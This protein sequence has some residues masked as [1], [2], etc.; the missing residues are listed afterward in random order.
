M[1][2][3]WKVTGFVTALLAVPAVVLVASANG[4]GP[5][6]LRER[7]VLLSPGE[8]KGRIDAALRATMG[9][10]SPPLSY[11]GADVDLYRRSDHWDHES[12]LET[13]VTGIVRVR[14]VVSRA[15]LPLLM[16]QVTPAWRALGSPNVVR[17][18]NSAKYPRLLG[19]GTV[20][21]ETSLA[22]NAVGSEDSSSYTV[23]FE[24]E[25]FGVL[26]QPARAYAPMSPLGR[27]PHDAAGYVVVDPVD[28]PYWSH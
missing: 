17:A 4:Y 20:G 8:A 10:V 12:S 2:T 19:A 26:Y 14:T 25:V 18:D 15:K 1:K 5:L 7:M 16:E 9:A 24:A 3:R 23:T 27:T 13:N 28:D 21:G 22:V 6:A 11:A